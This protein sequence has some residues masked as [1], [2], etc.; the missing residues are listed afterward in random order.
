MTRK[1]R[2]GIIMV[3]GVIILTWSSYALWGS[4]RIHHYKQLFL[5][6]DG[7]VLY[8]PSHGKEVILP[9]FF[10]DEIEVSEMAN[11]DNFESVKIYLSDGTE[12]LVKECIIEDF[13]NT[14]EG[15]LDFFYKRATMTFEVEDECEVVACSFA[16]SDTVEKFDVGSIKIKSYPAGMFRGS[17]FFESDLIDTKQEINYDSP[18]RNIPYNAFL[19]YVDNMQG[20]MTIKSI[21]LG[22]EF[23]DIDILNMK[24]I[25]NQSF[26]YNALKNIQEISLDDVEGHFGDVCVKEKENEIFVAPLAKDDSYTKEFRNYYINP[27]YHFVDE[28]GVDRVWGAEGNVNVFSPYIGNKEAVKELEKMIR[29]EGR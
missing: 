23:L 9:L 27:L 15:E 19:L 18:M 28:D 17:Y 8:C 3:L 4:R 11:G 24:Y 1:W 29:E 7:Q 2:I 5:P 25:G 26:S 13:N 16:Y 14:N 12:I 10:Y 22:C 20:E 6:C 21:D